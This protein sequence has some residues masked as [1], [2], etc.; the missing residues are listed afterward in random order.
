[1]DVCDPINSQVASCLA[2]AGNTF[3]IVR[4]WRSYGGSDPNAPTS[5]ANLKAAGLETDVYAFPCAQGDP[6]G[7]VR[8][9]GGGAWRVVCV[10]PCISRGACAAGRCPTRR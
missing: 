3:A 9:G 5:L 4:A 7:Q 6:A 1:V 2:Q 8:G 10:R